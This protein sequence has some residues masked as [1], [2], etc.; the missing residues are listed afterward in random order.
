LMPSRLLSL[1]E[2]FGYKGDRQLGLSLLYKAGGW[3]TTSDEPAVDHKT[4]GV[5]RTLCDMTLLIFH[6]VLSGFT[7]EGVDIGMAQKTTSND[8]Q[9]ECSSFSVKGG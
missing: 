4:E 5:R 8:T 9:T 3:S 1:I 7:Y 2:L 6:L